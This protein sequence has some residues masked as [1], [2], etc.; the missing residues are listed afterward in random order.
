VSFHQVVFVVAV[1]DRF[2]AA[3]GAVRVLAIVGAAGMGRSTRGRIRATFDQG[4]FIDMTLVA[5]VQMPVMQIIDV[6]FVFHCGVAA[7]GTVGMGVLI[8]G[9]VTAHSGCLLPIESF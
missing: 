7:S 2:M 1:R 9:W 8:V 5:A 3:S 4:V 6:A